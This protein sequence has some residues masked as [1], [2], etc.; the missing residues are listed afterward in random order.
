MARV[1]VRKVRKHR[2]RLFPQSSTGQI[3]ALPGGTANPD[4]A[5]EQ[6]RVGGKFIGGAFV[7][8]TDENNASY[9]VELGGTYP[10]RYWSKSAGTTPFYVDE[11]GVVTMA[12]ATVAGTTTMSG[13][14]TIT[15]NIVDASGNI[16]VRSTGYSRAKLR[17]GAGDTITTATNT[18]M[19]WV[20]EDADTDSYWNGSNDFLVMPFTGQYLI[21]AQA[22]FANNA[23]GTT[24]RAWLQE[25][26]G[27][28]HSVWTDITG[29][30]ESNVRAN[31]D[32]RATCFISDIFDFTADDAVR[33]RVRQNSGGNLNCSA[34]IAVLYLG[35]T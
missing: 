14:L 8:P 33:L 7:T 18:T 13:D 30:F 6:M 3:A 11:N 24:R 27:A 16:I 5:G 35:D 34:R 29:A 31:A 32:E 17:N 4:V 12:G 10:L 15:G 9:R 28:S 19:T 22:S 21:L 20:T 25:A 26:P 23:D 2:S 1:N